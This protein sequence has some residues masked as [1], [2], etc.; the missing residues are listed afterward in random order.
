[1][2]VSFTG[3]LK[4]RDIKSMWKTLCDSDSVSMLIFT[5]SSVHSPCDIMA[6]C[7]SVFE[8]VPNGYMAQLNPIALISVS[9]PR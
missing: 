2:H 6:G 1:M 3:Y 7:L 9:D 8:H 4:D 5:V